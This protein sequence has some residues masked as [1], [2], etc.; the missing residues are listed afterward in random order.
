VCAC[1]T[2]P[3]NF[4][5]SNDDFTD[6]ENEISSLNGKG[7]ILIIGDLNARVGDKSDFY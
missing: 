4:L 2:P 6:L 5:Y 3:T 7:N 1:Y